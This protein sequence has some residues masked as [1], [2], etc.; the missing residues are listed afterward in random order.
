MAV[1]ATLSVS[2][3][4]PKSGDTVTATYAV[5]G[6]DPTPDK[7]IAVDGTVTIGADPAVPV[8]ATVT[9]P[10]SPAKPETFTVPTCAGLTFKGTADP[11][12]FTAIVP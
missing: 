2:P 1:T 4:A 8:S 6:N 11:K 5:S 7:V 3:S 10:G 9:L 12:V